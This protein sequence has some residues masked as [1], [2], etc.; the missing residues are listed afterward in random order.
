[1]AIS[2]YGELQSAITDWLARSEL[3]GKATELITLAEAKLKRNLEVVETD[4]TL[5]GTVNSRR[6]DISA[7]SLIEPIALFISSDGDEQE[8]DLKADGTFPYLEH[9]GEPGYYAIDGTNI[10]FDRPLDEAYSFR[11]RYRG[12]FALSDA[13][14]TN[15]LL[16][17]HPDVYLSA[18]L[19]WGGLYI[20]DA[21]VISTQKA[22]LEEFIKEAKS[23]IAQKKRGVQTVDPALGANVDNYWDYQW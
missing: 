5:T 19:V 22:L 23:E 7:L 4:T 21:G 12:R 16:T 2:N 20:R 1:M 18:C 11:F 9:T 15:D 8:V 10:D 17:N 13:A 14:P 3:S 6:I